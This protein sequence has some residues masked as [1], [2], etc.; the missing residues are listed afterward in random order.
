MIDASVIWI[1]DIELN[2]EYMQ[3][4]KERR[5]RNYC[6]IVMTMNL[7]HSLYYRISVFVAAAVVSIFIAIE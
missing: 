3:N 1:A 5:T 6:S 2:I 4:I 7:Y